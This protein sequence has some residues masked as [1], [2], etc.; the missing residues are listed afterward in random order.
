[1]LEKPW[2]PV[3]QEPGKRSTL[4]KETSS[5]TPA[6]STAYSLTL[7][8]LTG[9]KKKVI[10]IGPASIIAEQAIQSELRTK[11]P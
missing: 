4:E 8:Q 2:S 7:C 6:P 11:R 5:P 10:I 9:K 3:S 1:M